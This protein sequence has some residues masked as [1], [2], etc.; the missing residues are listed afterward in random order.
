MTRFVPVRRTS[1]ARIVFALAMLRSKRRVYSVLQIFIA[2]ICLSLLLRTWMVMGLIAPVTVVGSSMAPSIVGQHIE[3]NCQH[4]GYAYSIGA[5]FA[6]SIDRAEC[7]QCGIPNIIPDQLPL[8]RGD[9]LWIHRLASKWSQPRRWEPVVFASP[10]DAGQLAVKRIIGLPGETIELRQGDVWCDGK[11]LVKPI[12]V[13]QAMRV[14]VHRETGQSHRWHPAPES[15]WRWQ[16][17][18]WRCADSSSQRQ[19]WIQYHHSGGKVLTDD[20]PYNAG[21]SRKLFLVRDFWLAVQL[22]LAG[23]GYLAVRLDDGTSVAEVRLFP[24]QGTVQLS[25]DG[26]P[27]VE[28][29]LSPTIH[30]AL[31]DGEVKLDLCNFDRTLWVAVNGSLQLR[32]PLPEGRPIVGVSEPFSVGSDGTYA[33]IL[34]SR[35]YRDVYYMSEQEAFGYTDSRVEYPVGKGTVFVLGDNIAVSLDSRRWGPLP[36]RYI[37]GSPLF[38]R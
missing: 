23:A 33:D 36:A 24:E 38:L 9:A 29:Q 27:C 5:E 35:I 15:G 16:Q 17:G 30:K 25:L 6:D 20:L 28:S 7:P 37:V 31:R 1:P 10:A 26:A 14:L 22:R 13:Q 2:S 4:C 12:P 18:A 11:R 32:H 19:H 34:D 3:V 8:Q 21:L